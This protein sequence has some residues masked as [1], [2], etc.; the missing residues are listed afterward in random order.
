[1]YLHFLVFNWPR[2]RSELG[3]Y[4]LKR[5]TISVILPIQLL[6]TGDNASIYVCTCHDDSN[7]D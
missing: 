7:A 1:V 5:N 6:K 3:W 4:K 2:E